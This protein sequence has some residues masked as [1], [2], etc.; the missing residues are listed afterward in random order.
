[1]AADIIAPPVRFSSHG[2]DIEGTLYRPRDTA[3]RSPALVLS[4]GRSRDIVGLDWLGRGLAERGHVVLAHRYRDGDVRYYDRDAEDIQVAV[5]LLAARDDVDAAR[6][7]LIGHSRGGMGSLLA[8]SADRRVRATVCLAGPTDHVR[9]VN[10]LKAYAP[11]RHAEMIHS[12]GGSPEEAPDYY[13]AISAV[14]HAAAIKVPV[15]LVYGTL[16]LV[17]PHDHGIWMRD[18]LVAAGNARSRLEVIPG[19]GHFFEQGFG[20]YLFDRIVA[21]AAGWYAETLL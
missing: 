9:M 16:D 7:G 3:G 14:N 21:L 20:P 2:G 17:C 11:S 13:R 1:M 12:H 10:G 5:S 4:P 18:A 15:L 19:M 8:T 6:I